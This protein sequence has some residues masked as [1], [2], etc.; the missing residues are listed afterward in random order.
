MKILKIVQYD[1]HKL[2]YNMAY[3]VITEQLMIIS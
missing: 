3:V 1:S 2:T